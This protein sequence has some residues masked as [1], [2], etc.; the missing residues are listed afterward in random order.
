MTKKLK[1]TEVIVVEQQQPIQQPNMLS[2]E[3]TK[4][5][6]E[7]RCIHPLLKEIEP[8]IFHKFV[9]FSEMDPKTYDVKPSYCQCN[10]CGMIHKIV[11]IGKSEILKKEETSLLES[12][13]EIKF[14]VPNHL[15]TILEKYNSELHVWQEAKFIY[16][17][18]LYG[19][20]V[21]LSKE[22][23][24]PEAAVFRGKYMII[25]GEV[26]V[27]IETFE[28]DEGYILV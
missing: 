7:C 17:N 22:K 19:K 6:I 3:Y 27:K 18:K 26:L 10:N 14:G 4:H 23:D 20:H 9:V 13:D 21:I 12:I 5:M 15:R 8:T 11:S 28:Q 2:A 25:L 24:S 16:D 1:K